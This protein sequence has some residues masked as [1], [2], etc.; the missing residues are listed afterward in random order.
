MREVPLFHKRRLAWTSRVGMGSR[1]GCTW[2]GHLGLLRCERRT[3]IPGTLSQLTS[4]KSV[5]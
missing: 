2:P 3:V 4:Q 1:H 5:S